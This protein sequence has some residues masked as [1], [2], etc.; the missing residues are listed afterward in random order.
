MRRCIISNA[1]ASLPVVR[2]IIAKK[3]RNRARPW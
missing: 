1:I 3:S 2:A